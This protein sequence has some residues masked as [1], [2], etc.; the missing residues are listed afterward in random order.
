M[1]AP[2][3]NEI[4][5]EQIAYWKRRN[6][7]ATEAWS[8]LTGGPVWHADWWE[9]RGQMVRWLLVHGEAPAVTRLA[10]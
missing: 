7:T 1:I 6:V 2:V 4:A 8:A 5:N 9:V 10:A 3:A